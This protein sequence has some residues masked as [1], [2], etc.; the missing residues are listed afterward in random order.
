MSVN[1]VCVCRVS[2]MSSAAVIF[3]T[4]PHL[5]STMVKTDKMSGLMLTE[6]ANWL[7]ADQVQHAADTVI[8]KNGTLRVLPVA[9]STLHLH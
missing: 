5:D 2:V 7:P 1:S 6:M 8:P 3:P 4:T 9:G